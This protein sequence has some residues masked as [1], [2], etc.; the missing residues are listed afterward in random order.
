MNSALSV[1]WSRQI[2][3]YLRNKQRL[4]VSLVQPILF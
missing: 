4:F 1:M 3:E 2:K